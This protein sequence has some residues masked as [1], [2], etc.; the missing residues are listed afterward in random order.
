MI[1]I[2]GIQ[3]RKFLNNVYR[4]L[5]AKGS[6]PDD[7]DVRRLFSSYFSQNKLGSPA[8]IKF[9]ELDQEDII[10]VDTLNQLMSNTLLNVEVLYDLVW[11]NNN[12][13]LS[14]VTAL[15][16]KLDSLRAK[17]KELESIVDQL[18]FSNENSDGYFYSILD[19]FSTTEKV[20]LDLSTGYVDTDKGF[21]SVPV[22][23]SDLSSSV[24]ADQIT[25]SNVSM[26]KSLNGQ[27]IASAV[28]VSDFDTVFDG[29]T[30]T[31]WSTVIESAS[32]SV[33]SILLDIPIGSS[34][35]I[36]KV[37]LRLVSASPCGVGL[38]LVPSDNSKANVEI[39]KDSKS[40]YDRFSFT[41]PNQKYSKI[42]LTLY[43]YEHDEIV[44]G[45][46]LPYKYR[47]GVSEVMIGADYH[48]KKGVI[49]S[50]PLSLPRIDNK[51]LEI[52]TV[53]LDSD[54]TSPDDSI[55]RYYVASDIPDA[56][57]IS[58]FNWYAIEPGGLN[59]GNFATSV[60]FLSSNLK[61][62]YFNST[63]SRFIDVVVDNDSP[64]LNLRNPIPVPYA[65]EKSAYRYKIV[66]GDVDLVSPFILSGI[67]GL[68]SYFEY[69]SSP[70]NLYKSVSYWLGQVSDGSV[71]A[72][73][74]KNQ[75]VVVDSIR[76]SGSGYMSFKI[77]CD[78][79]VNTIQ[80]IVKSSIDFN[81]SVYLNGNLICDLPSGNMSTSMEWNF[82][83][84]VNNIQ[85]GYD[86]FTNFTQ[87]VSLMS[88]ISLTEYG[89]IYLD[90]FTYL[91]PV[92]FRRRSFESLN[93][94]TIQE[95]YGQKQIISTKQIQSNSLVRY[96]QNA[97]DAITSIRYRIDMFRGSNPLTSSR[98]NAVRIKF[99]HT[100]S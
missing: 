34:F 91:D 32:P 12:E 60:S 97:S 51:N 65:S 76:P 31:F 35:S 95:V 11:E 29:L 9:I 74:I 46:S 62:E 56:Q 85:I 5:Y 22:I 75:S 94:F 15:N 50:Q 79:D 66:P 54:Y 33:A 10:N 87:T 4:S 19:S 36:S 81:L 64:N 71:T 44:N 41:V 77:I 89:T 67:N 57:S 72:D 84:G 53:A 42:L 13:I 80:T 90:Y 25:S 69:S 73:L 37:D 1:D 23:T 49:V 16:N 30:D 18:I 86:N 88:G 96:Y 68:R 63:S 27:V 98:V 83:K 39:V 43:K 48:D 14:V 59:R 93:A 100:D 58:D 38:I 52:S 7:R 28:S 26:T 92:E 20:D 45:S 24:A 61:T 70:A 78:E 2:P 55:V 82:I 47:F 17:R 21:C 99:K 6:L 40:D 3:K 8:G